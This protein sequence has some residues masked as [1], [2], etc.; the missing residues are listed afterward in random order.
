MRIE[1]QPH[2]S[3]AIAA[4]AAFGSASGAPS[5][6]VMSA[7]VSSV[8]ALAGGLPA[9]LP[10]SAGRCSFCSCRS[11]ITS[12]LAMRVVSAVILFSILTFKAAFAFSRDSIR[13]CS[14]G[15]E[16]ASGFAADADAATGLVMAAGFTTRD[17]DDCAIVVLDVLALF[18]FTVLAGAVLPAD[19]ARAGAGATAL[20]VVARPFGF[21]TIEVL[22]GFAGVRVEAFGFAAGAAPDRAGEAVFLSAAGFVFAPLAGFEAGVS[23]FLMPRGMIDLQK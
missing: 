11:T 14:L 16:A 19:R 1:R 3:A 12:R 23:G 10:L 8:A 20:A 5:G 7:A 21:W 2:V 4:S 9:A 13:R 6:L 22:T 17:A 18:G 15:I